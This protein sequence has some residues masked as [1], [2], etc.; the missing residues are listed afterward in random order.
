MEIPATSAAQPSAQSSAQSESVISS[1]FETFL[2]MLTAQM[3]NQDP[4]NPLDSQDFATQL[5]TFSGVEQ[6]VKTNDLL[7]AL[8]SQ[9][10]SSGLAEMSGWVGMEARIAAPANFSGEPIEIVANPPIFADSTDLVV[11][12]E[13]GDVVQ[14]VSVPVSDEPIFWDGLDT[15]GTS[16]PN[17]TYAFSVEAFSDGEI[18]DTH[19]PD[20]FAEVAEVRTV[21]GQNVV[22]LQGGDIFPSGAV[23]GLR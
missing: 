4:L 9:I 3:E 20:I 7:S 11:R 16:F 18:I 13:A 19:T 21:N 22:V 14:R 10:M 1:D 17:G 12:N 8:A 2:V 15:N 6:Q 5:A 23:T